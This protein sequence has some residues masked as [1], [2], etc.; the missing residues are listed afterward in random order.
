LQTLRFGA[1]RFAGLLHNR[2]A[3]VLLDERMHEL[4][5][6]DAPASP[7]GIAVT[8]SGDIVVVGEQSSRVAR[9]AVIGGALTPT[10]SIVLEGDRA[11]VRRTFPRHAVFA[12]PRRRLP[13]RSRARR[14]ARRRRRNTGAEWPDHPARRADLG[15]RRDRGR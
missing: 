14:P 10:G 1:A 13:D 12:L 4:A 9:Y 15:L 3:V 7:S 6:A 5:R 8:P 2:D 11:R